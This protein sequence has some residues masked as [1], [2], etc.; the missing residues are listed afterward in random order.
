[1]SLQ[2]S[3]PSHL[4]RRAQEAIAAD[5]LDEAAA[6]LQQILDR[7]SDN[8]MIAAALA[9][10]HLKRSDIEAHDVAIAAAIRLAPDAD[11]LKLRAALA[12]PPMMSS[13]AEIQRLRGRTMDRLAALERESLSIPHPLRD[14]P[15][16]TYHFV[17]H[18][19]DDRPL[20]EAVGRI[21]AAASP[22][23][24]AVAPHT[25]QPRQPGPIRLG[26][27]SPHLKDHTIGQLFRGTIAKLDDRFTRAT[28]FCEDRV[29][30]AALQIAQTADE[31]ALI[32]RSLATARAKI[33][34]LQLD[35]LL[36][37]DVGMDTLTHFLAHAR[38]AHRQCTTWGHPITTGLST[39]DAF[40]SM[41]DL[42][43]DGGAPYSEQLITQPAPHICFTPDIPP[44]ATRAE[45]GLP[46]GRLYGC[47]QAL[48]K[49]HPDFDDILIDILDRD[50]A[51]TLVLHAGKTQRWKAALL[52]RLEA[53][54]PGIGRRIH[55][56]TNMPRTAY[57]QTLAALSVMLDPT[58]FG[59][60]NTTLESLAVGTPV[61]TLPPR[62]ARGRIAYAL[63]RRLGWTDGIASSPAEYAEIAV[64]LAH[65]PGP[66][67][68]TIRALAP[69]LFD[70]DEGVRQLGDRLAALAASPRH[71]EA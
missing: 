35:V 17:Y 16:L 32:P 47:P 61:V 18:G 34:A 48:A 59:G 7:Q 4:L 19:L 13:V 65:D 68:A 14:L 44:S 54:S 38:L 33:A 56:L 49:L 51:G 1:M 66:A 39:I 42:E 6:A 37:L 12:C 22:G 62:F 5:A 2:S 9:R 64:R 43:P 67:S 25:L 50:R 70:N 23:L 63:C 60:G 36:F 28:I 40:L 69:Q 29:D 55:W 30:D 8:A 31:I 10:I 26:I 21:L 46:V 3:T 11:H 41:D 20:H 52:A 24:R 15:T 53:K 71:G 57:I 58:P 27:F 45:L